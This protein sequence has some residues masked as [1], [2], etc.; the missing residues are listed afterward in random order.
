MPTTNEW[1]D[2]LSELTDDVQIVCRYA[3]VVDY[4]ECET[5]HNPVQAQDFESGSV[6]LYCPECETCIS[7]PH[8]HQDPTGNSV[9]S[10]R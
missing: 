7:H 1:P 5:E 8:L 3:K 9:D 4:P 6:R 10:A 2:R